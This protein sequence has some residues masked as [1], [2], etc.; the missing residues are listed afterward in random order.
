MVRRIAARQVNVPAGRPSGALDGIGREILAVQKTW[1]N[2]VLPFID[3]ACRR[4]YNAPASA[5]RSVSLPDEY[6]K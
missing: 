2:F 4:C 1:H 6:G 3:A 5:T